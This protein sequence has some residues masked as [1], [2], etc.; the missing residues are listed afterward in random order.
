[1]WAPEQVSL[2]WIFRWYTCQ[3]IH[4]WCDET[5][6]KSQ[7]DINKTE[8]SWYLRCKKK[9]INEIQKI[10]N[11]QNTHYG[12]EKKYFHHIS[13]DFR[14]EMNQ[15]VQSFDDTLIPAWRELL[16]FE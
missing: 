2:I 10:K 15:L 13:T 12:R 9:K 7:S 14:A 5:E 16:Y 6:I 4:G 3:F 8:D 1:M 11:K